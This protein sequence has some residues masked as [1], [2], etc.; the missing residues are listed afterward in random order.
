MSLAHSA[1]ENAISPNSNAVHVAILLIVGLMVT[2]DLMPLQKLEEAHIRD[3]EMII[4][5][6][7]VEHKGGL[8]QGGVVIVTVLHL[9]VDPVWVLLQ[10]EKKGEKASAK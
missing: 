5:A 10:M 3:G 2:I 1:Q 8:K 7:V 9:L 4:R 6:P